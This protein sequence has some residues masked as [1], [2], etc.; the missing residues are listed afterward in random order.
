MSLKL[1]PA[2]AECSLNATNSAIADLRRNEVAALHWLFLQHVV[3]RHPESGRSQLMNRT[4]TLRLFHH[5]RSLGQGSVYTQDAK[6]QKLFR[7]CATG[8]EAHGHISFASLAW[9]LSF[10]AH[11]HIGR[12]LTLHAAE[13]VYA[14]LS[15]TARNAKRVPAICHA[16]ELAGRRPMVLVNDTVGAAWRY[17]SAFTCSEPGSILR[18]QVCLTFKS[19]IL[20][21]KIKGI[22]LRQG[23]EEAADVEMLLNF[24]WDQRMLVHNHALLQVQN[25]SWVLVGGMEAFG[26]TNRTCRKLHSRNRPMCLEQLKKD[27]ERVPANKPARGSNSVV[28]GVRMMRGTG[29]TWSHC[30][31]DE[32]K[33]I[34]RGTDPPGCVDRRSDFTGFPHHVAC[35]FDGR[36]SLVVMP[37]AVSTKYRIYARAN[38]RY[39]AITGGRNVQ[40]SQSPTL[41]AGSWTPWRPV[42]I[43]GVD[44]SSFDL[45]F[46][47]V[48]SNPVDNATLMALMPV[49]EPP[50]ACI[51]VAFS[52]DG[53]TFSRPRNL[54]DAPIALRKHT[55]VAIE[56][57]HRGGY[58]A[59]SEDH[60]VANMIP[61][62]L[63]PTDGLLLYIHHAVSGMTYRDV[64]PHVAGYQVLASDLREWTQSGLRALDE[65]AG[66]VVAPPAKVASSSA[67]A[68]AAVAA[69]ATPPPP[70]ATAGTPEATASAA[71]MEMAAARRARNAKALRWQA[72]K[73]R[74]AATA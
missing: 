12:A 62:P 65:A 25:D 68:A 70:R 44:T 13:L 72:R 15:A 16:A 32:P 31:W 63:H 46:F 45:Y 69:A 26:R 11:G 14:N 27:V 60:P 59:R 30:T 42:E 21:D 49:A 41:A 37:A 52:R 24:P 28:A 67:A 1:D 6:V 35:E 64:K 34:I 38:L 3:E 22:R 74:R 17:Y 57:K 23:R 9:I 5:L 4:S 53:V 73:S 56:D 10:F 19:A 7:K 8:S 61:D 39:G 48:Q 43:L 20:G 18:D 29:L 54:R 2:R 66:I 51:A 47:A 36:F 58:D 50:W 33:V 55:T 40:T 71:S